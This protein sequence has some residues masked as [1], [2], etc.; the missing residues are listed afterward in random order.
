[1]KAYALITETFRRKASIRIVHASWFGIYG[2]IFL[3]PFTPETWHWGP[4]L[5]GWSG[6]LLPLLLSEGILGDDI[7]SGRIRL[8]VTEP[9][10]PREL[11]LWRFLGLSLQAAV[12]IGLAGAMI[13]LLQRL[14]GRGSVDRFVV[15]MLASWLLFNVWAALSTSLSVVL[16]R[17]HN[18]MILFVV[19]VGV[20]LSLSL[21]TSFFPKSTGVHVLHGMVR[22]ACPPVELLV[23]MGR[24]KCSLSAGVASVAHSLM[25]TA[26]YG[27][28]GIVLL[29]RREFKCVAD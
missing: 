11:Y 29:G 24:G 5:F 4:F 14:T 7:A 26:L 25:V 18:A 1:M 16:R 23:R 8:L 22:Y 9:I 28:A 15:W 10:R 17:A 6:C 19:T 27:A 12:H 20:F 3:V 13:L 2:T 21:L